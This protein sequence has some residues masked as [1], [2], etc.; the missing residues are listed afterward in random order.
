MW[1]YVENGQAAGPV[2]EEVFQSLAQAGRVTLETL[3]WNEH[4]D[5]W[6]PASQTKLAFIF[7]AP[8]AGSP[9]PIRVAAVAMPASSPPPSLA[10]P[11]PAA[12]PVESEKKKIIKTL[13][14]IAG[15]AIG[16]F[17][18]KLLPGKM[19]IRIFFGGAAGFLCGLIPY[20]TGRHKNPKL[21]KTAMTC[22]IISGMAFGVLLALPVAIVFTIVIAVKSPSTEG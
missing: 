5:N 9:G 15:A 19:A 18:V 11:P 21:A 7:P 20:F 10:A 22:S 1:H 13:S 4:M 2:S 16:Y 6:L 8:A 12:A 3:V 17:A 14:M